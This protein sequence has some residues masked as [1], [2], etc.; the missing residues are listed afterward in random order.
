[1]VPPDYDQSRTKVERQGIVL[2]PAYFEDKLVVYQTI[3]PELERSAQKP[4]IIFLMNEIALSI[5]DR[6]NIYHR[7]LVGDS[8]ECILK[9]NECDDENLMNHILDL[10]GYKV[11]QAALVGR[12]SSFANIGFLEW[13]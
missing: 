9:L 3:P 5:N 1:M 4:R 13:I 10:C 7:K 12:M 6:P 2:L 8:P 11:P